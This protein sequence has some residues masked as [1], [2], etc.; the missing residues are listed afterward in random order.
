MEYINRIL[1]DRIAEESADFQIIVITGP[2]QTGKTTL[3]KHLFP[4]YEYYNLEDGIF[5]EAISADPR[6][7]ILESKRNKIIDEIQNLPELF[8]YIQL[9][10]DEKPERRYVLTGSSDFSLMEKITQSLAGRA[11][12]FTLLPFSFKEVRK[13]V[14]DQPTDALMF[15]GFYPGTLVKKISPARFYSNYISTYIEKDVRQIKN[16][17]NLDLFRT[18]LRMLAGRAATEFNASSLSIELGVT[19]PTLKSWLGILK[20]SYIVFALQPYYSNIN[21]R[22][23]KTPKIYFYD[24]GILCSLLGIKTWKQLCLHPLRGAIFENMAVAELLKEKYNKGELY[25]LCFYR[26][27]GGREVDVMEVDFTDINL[28]EIKSS[29]NFNKSFITNLKYLKSLLGEKVKSEKLIYDGPTVSP[30]ILNIREL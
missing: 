27:N 19:S 29:R 10:V 1:G 9:S 2:R 12:L 17:E 20:T 13:Y 11:A 4:D 30:S 18:F 21:K 22:L 28:Y 5:R 15:N 23:T 6:G 25:D 8:S 26:E 7:F 16:I 14:E 24:T 3:S